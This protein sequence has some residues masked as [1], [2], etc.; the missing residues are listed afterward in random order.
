VRVAKPSA[1]QIAQMRSG[2]EEIVAELPNVR[3]HIENA[4]R[5][6]PA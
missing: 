2:V 3:R 4:Y 5:D 1:S 6:E